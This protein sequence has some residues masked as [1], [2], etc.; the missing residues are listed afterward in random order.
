ME[1]RTALAL[2][3]LTLSACSGASS[4]PGPEPT[5]PV[6]CGADLPASVTVSEGG[7]VTVAIPEGTTAEGSGGAVATTEGGKVTIRAPYLASAEGEVGLTLSCGKTIPIELRP[8]AWKQLATWTESTGAKAREYGAWWIDPAGT[9]ALVV[10]GGFHYVPAQFTPAND[11]WRF[12][13]ASSTW[14]ALAGEGLPT[15]P[16]GRAAPIPDQRAV[17]FFGGASTKES[18]GLDT[19]PSLYRLDFDE[20][21]VTPT[22]KTNLGDVPGSYTGSFV[23]DS[24]RGRFLSLCGQD[25]K[26]GFNCSVD[27]YTEA[28]GFAHL[29]PTGEPPAGRNGFHYAYDEATDRVVLFGGQVGSD[30]LDIDGETW[31][32]EL[33]SEPPAWKRLFANGKGPERR[34]NG[35]FAL[36]PLGHRL[37]VWGGTPDGKRSVPGLQVLA[38]DRGSE[39]WSSVELPSAVT[40][41]TSGIGVSDAA[42][43]RILFG[44]GNESAPLRDLWSLDVANV[45]PR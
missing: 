34:R 7:L 45:S 20:A 6:A 16:G 4:N 13:F 40:K 1:R 9:G 18:G 29:A 22:K 8:L 14:S 31:A 11:A 38:L 5:I 24:K 36:D 15:L 12:D 44:L 33:S 3:V 2:I 19:P 41:R 17:L 39:A 43:D 26:T 21:R 25:A 28:G 35:A 10:F 42:R 32:L 23:F 27:A 30:N 37:F